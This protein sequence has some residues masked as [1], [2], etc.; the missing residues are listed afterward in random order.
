MA[1]SEKNQHSE[2]LALCQYRLFMCKLDNNQE[3]NYQRAIQFELF[4]DRLDEYDQLDALKDLANTYRALLR[5]NKVEEIVEKLKQKAEF[6]YKKILNNDM[7]H[8]LSRPPFTYIA[9]SYLLLGSVHKHNGDYEKAIQYIQMYADLDWVKDKDE[10]TLT[11][12][13]NFEKWAKMNVLV[14]KLSAGDPSVLADYVAYIESNKEEVLLSLINI[15]EFANRYHFNI[16]DI[17]QRF[18]V[19]SLI[20]NPKYSNRLYSQQMIEEL[21]ARFNYELAHYY[22]NKGQN[23]VGF[24]HLIKSLEKSVSINEKHC[25]IKCIGLF[26]S[27]REISDSGTKLAYKKFISEVYTNEKKIGSTP[28]G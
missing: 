15:I 21:Q 2:R 3:R 6:Q 4:V 9:Y 27:F 1:L 28:V 13:E 7:V 26:E 24:W 18:E 20:T 14:T 12:K 22:L 5:W 25:I 10:D 23:G 11:W 16:D 17:L 19:S 8:K